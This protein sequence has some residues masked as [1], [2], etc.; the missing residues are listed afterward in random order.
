MNGAS[1]SY[2]ATARRLSQDRPEEHDRDPPVGSSGRR[3]SVVRN[4]FARY[5]GADDIED[6]SSD[7]VQ[8]TRSRPTMSISSILNDHQPAVSPTTPSRQEDEDATSQ[9][10]PSDAVDPSPRS[11]PPVKGSAGRGKGRKSAGGAR[12]IASAAAAAAAA[13]SPTPSDGSAVATGDRSSLSI[14]DLL[15]GPSKVSERGDAIKG[16]L[17]T[18][19][20][21]R[22]LRRNIPAPRVQLRLKEGGVVE[23]G[24]AAEAEAVRARTAGRM[25]PA[26]ESLPRAQQISQCRTPK[27]WAETR[28]PMAAHKCT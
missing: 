11:E 4:G 27:A 28:T 3:G 7:D 25:L 16:T 12:S 13:T 24:A 2:G 23:A 15:G 6:E 5:N 9:Y 21:Q 17:L 8:V 20:L 19:D 10:Y 14:S 18:S 26:R 22:Y 1:P